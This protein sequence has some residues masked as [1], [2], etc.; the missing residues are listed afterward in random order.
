MDDKKLEGIAKTLGAR[1]VV[2]IG[3]NLDSGPIGWMNSLRVYNKLKNREYD[4]N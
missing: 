2:N 1:R 3:N 4:E